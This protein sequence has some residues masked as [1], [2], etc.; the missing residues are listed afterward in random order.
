VGN[1]RI[2]LVDPANS[3]VKTIIESGL[4]SFDKGGVPEVAARSL[5]MDVKV[6]SDGIILIADMGNGR[7]RRIDLESGIITTVV[8]PPERLLKGEHV[9]LL[10]MILE[11]PKHIVFDRGALFI[12]DTT[13]HRILKLSFKGDSLFKNKSKANEIKNVTKLD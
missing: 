5:L 6:A 12:A 3:I 9:P 13:S 8:G 1:N 11:Q 10:P 2:R 7:V 4:E